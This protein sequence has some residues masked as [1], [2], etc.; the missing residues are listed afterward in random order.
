MRLY[1]SLQ[2]D[3]RTFAPRD[4]DHVS[5]YFCGP[6]VYNYIHLGNARPFVISQVA[7][8]YFQSLG[9][10]VTLVENVTDIDDRIIQKAIAEGR[11]AKE[12]ADEYRLAYIEDTDKLGLGRPDIEPL[13]TENI[14]EIVHLI[15]QLVANGHAYQSGAD[16]YYD[17]DSFE[18]YGRLSKQQIAEMRHGAR[19]TPGEDKAD[20]LD[21]TLWKG[22]KPGEP[23]WESPWGPGR[24]GWHIEC[25]AMA[26][27]YLGPGF[28]I[29][30]GGRD[31]IFPHHENELAQAEGALHEPFVQFWM[32]NGMLNLRDEKMAKSVGNIFLLREALK[33][34]APETLILYF[35]SSHYRSPM[36]FSSELLD[37][38]AQQVYRLRN[39]FAAL[40]DYDPHV[41]SRSRPTAVGTLVVAPGRDDARLRAQISARRRGFDDALA[42]DLNTAAALAEVF[43]LV[44]EVN[45]AVNAGTITQPV[46]EEAL[47]SLT[48]MVHVLGLDAVS[49]TDTQIPADVVAMAEDR[50]RA[51]GAKDF[52]EADR[53]RDAIRERGYEV[54]DAAEGFK[55]VRSRLS[56]REHAAPGGERSMAGRDK[57]GSASLPT[58]PGQGGP[59]AL[60]P[61][62]AGPPAADRTA[63]TAYH[64]GLRPARRRGRPSES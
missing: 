17:V 46:A 32:H 62:P 63:P 4:G 35:V 7:K 45:I 27:R 23:S 2:Q 3:K 31:L 21:F 52:T 36:E 53:L 39:V 10:R 51:R 55:L 14:G 18:G 40:S 57:R 54:R 6:T 33:R 24:P 19:I 38:A 16:V 48:A 26:L 13:A 30:G 29:H 11:T 9:Y 34:Y 15:E 20:P 28:D 49:R 44:R 59:G 5:M 43:A 25:S 42:D 12:V 1:D 61:L 56:R 37:E 41:A 64:P 50:V 58:P 8:R 47:R 22:A 60:R